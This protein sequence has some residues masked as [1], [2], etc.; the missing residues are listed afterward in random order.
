MNTQTKTVAPALARSIELK[1]EHRSVDS[2]KPYKNNARTHSDKQVAQIASSIRKFGFVNPVLIGD[3]GEVI[4]GHGRVLAAK[5]LGIVEVPTLLLAHLTEAERRAYRI[6]DN[7]L[8]ELAGWDESILRIEFASLAELD[9]DFELELTGFDT[10]EIDLI[11]DGGDTVSDED[12][13][14]PA[15][16]PGPAVTRPGD[17]W[18]LGDHRLICGDATDTDVLDQLMQGDKADC[19]FT[20]PP[21]NVKIDGN[22]CGSGTI[23]DRE[24]AMASG[25]MDVATFTKL[26]RDAL[27]VMASHS[28]DGAIHFVCMD[29]RHMSELQQAGAAVYSELKNLVVC[30]KTNGG[31][32]TFYRSH[33]HVRS[34]R[35]RSLPHQCLVLSGRQ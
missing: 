20:D 26:L 1:I 12:D 31:M 3:G 17:V 16:E 27:S 21:Y 10:A 7:K 6:A 29:W 4:A 13:Q 25:E 18:I 8:A 11:L 32:G 2:L 24:F 19:V 9:L 22:V 5:Q 15:P 23:K 34:W 30:A 14:S 33:Q 35:I 28:R